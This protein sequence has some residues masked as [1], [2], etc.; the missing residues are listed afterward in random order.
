M[1]MFAAIALMLTCTQDN[2]LTSAES[3][4]GWKLLFDGK[5]ER[6]WGCHDDAPHDRVFPQGE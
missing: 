1:S 2:V 4:A 3:K 5:T 6:C